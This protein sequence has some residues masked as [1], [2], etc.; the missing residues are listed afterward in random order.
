MKKIPLR[1]RRTP[2]ARENVFRSQFKPPNND[3]FELRTN[4]INC[5]KGA[6]QREA[7]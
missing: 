5:R 7:S 3:F 1:A 4:K 2:A 6:E